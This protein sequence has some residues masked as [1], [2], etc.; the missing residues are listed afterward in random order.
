MRESL[1]LLWLLLLCLAACTPA[2]S[3]ND[4]QRAWLAAAERWKPD[5][6]AFDRASP[7][8]SDYDPKQLPNDFAGLSHAWP[9]APR[10]PRIPEAPHMSA[11]E[12]LTTL[13]I[14][15]VGLSVEMFR[16]GDVWNEVKKA[17]VFHQ[18]VLPP[19]EDPRWEYAGGPGVAEKRNADTLEMAL[20]DMVEAWPIPAVMVFSQE[21]I[22]PESA[23]YKYRQANFPNADAEYLDGLRMP[24]GLHWSKI[25]Q[26]GT[27][28]SN[29]PD[30]VV[31]GIFR[32]FERH[33][34]MPVLLVFAS[35][36]IA[37]TQSYAALLLARRERVEWLRPFVPYVHINSEP[38]NPLFNGWRVPPPR[39]FKPTPSFSE[40]WTHRQFKQ[41]DEMP[42]LATLHR[43][44]VAR[45]VD[46][47]DKPLRQR[48]QQAALE[49]AW[50]TMVQT[51]APARVFFD[52]G[53]PGAGMAELA[54]VLRQAGSPLD[55][56]E[57]DEGIDVTA[58]LGDTGTAAP[59]VALA[60]ATMATAES[61]S[62]SAIIPLRRK[63][64]ASFFL[65]TPAQA[66]PEGHFEPKLRPQQSTEPDLPRKREA[67]VSREPMIYPDRRLID[68]ELDPIR[69][70][71]AGNDADPVA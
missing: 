61:G 68:G 43:P 19:N 32:T 20:Y 39:P 2:S 34:D 56:T 47:H 35:G 65:I 27:V 67:E 52:A 26:I 71:G 51:A 60:L 42:T 36:G 64:E 63:D 31:E 45:R 11:Q 24:A 16:Q 53:R 5:P 49:Q 13:D 40:P 57:P 50:A 3:M 9:G 15:G 14:V 17:Q 29:T 23:G 48:E 28:Y 41:W 10:P 37:P 8:P 22:N 38:L 54:P 4:D 69:M 12:R 55:L 70:L 21:Q 1:R 18:N 44:V 30:E 66:Q 46:E 33:P 25:S 58:R 7:R 6:L 62:P 59:F